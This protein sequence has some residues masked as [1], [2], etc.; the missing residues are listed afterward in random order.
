MILLN[1]FATNQ[2][3]HKGSSL[4]HALPKIVDQKIDQKIVDQK[5]NAIHMI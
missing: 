4:M 2:V 1:I 3:I 5:N